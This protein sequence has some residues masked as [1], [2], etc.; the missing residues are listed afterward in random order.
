MQGC[1]TCWRRYRCNNKD[2]SM[3]MACVDYETGENQIEK[4]SAQSLQKKAADKASEKD[5][6]LARRRGTAKIEAETN[7][8]RE[9]D[10]DRH[11]VRIGVR[12]CNRRGNIALLPDGGTILERG[13]E[14]ARSGN[15]YDR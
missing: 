7:H 9:G 1:R 11:R 12:E 15:D 2:R 13:E 4:T 10:R 5:M 14:D 8:G 6:R 3:G